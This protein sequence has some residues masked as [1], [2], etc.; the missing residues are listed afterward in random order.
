MSD[1]RPD[2]SRPEI[3]V[4][5]DL[6]IALHDDPA[7]EA[8]FARLPFSHK[9]EYIDWILEARLPDTRA[10]RID[11]ALRRIAGGSERG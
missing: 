8:A 6:Q 4:P 7:A 9:R 11:E 1:E 3:A 5:H 2:G 10:R